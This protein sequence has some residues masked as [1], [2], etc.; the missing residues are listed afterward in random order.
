MAAI[1]ESIILE[2][3]FPNLDAYYEKYP[4]NFSKIQ[5]VVL[6][7]EKKYYRYNLINKVHLGL[8][9]RT[10]FFYEEQKFGAMFQECI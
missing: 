5:T 2:P 3:W 9:N 7:T 1:L 8:Q 6:Q 10:S 4:K